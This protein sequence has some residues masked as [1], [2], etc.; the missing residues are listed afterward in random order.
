M[1]VTARPAQ[2]AS[3]VLTVSRGLQVLRAFR[4]ERTPLTNAVLVQ[5]TGLSKATVSRLTSTL[6][7]V[8][9]LHRTPGSRAFELS[10]G[11]LGI[12]HAFVASSAALRAAD[13]LLRELAD[14]LGVSVA[15][16]TGEGA[17]MVYVAYRA[18]RGVATLRL[19]VG[20]VLPMATTAIGHAYV[21]G[22]PPA[23]RRRLVAG[24]VQTA[25]ARAQSVQRCIDRSFDQLQ[26]TGSCGVLSEFQRDAYGVALPVRV[27][28][29]ASVMGLSCGK[30][31]M[32]PDLDASSKRLT[33][34]L[35]Q[36]ARR[37]E[38]LL[39]DFEDLL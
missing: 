4:S 35:K 22:H 18:G 2:G 28:R 30:A 27:G 12:G 37:L 16:A 21:W 11:A 26:S 23:E 32:K 36:T 17:D 1:S 19:G 34:G 39:A 5:R 33:P 7:S 15:L 6:L 29:C 13:P 25:G 9:F 10:S 8:G 14:E 20:S 24:L 38:T 31:Q 3:T